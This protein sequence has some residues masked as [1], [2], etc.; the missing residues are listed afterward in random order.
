MKRLF[1][2][3]GD[4]SGD[5][6]AAGVVRHLREKDARIEVAA[7]GGH[8]LERE[9][10]RLLS[11]QSEMGQ[12]GAGAVFGAPYHFFLG[13]KILRFLEEFRPDGVLLIDYGVFNLWMAGRL[14]KRGYRTFYFIPPQV[15]ASR[16][17]RI[18]KI[19]R[20]IDHVFCI[21]P[22]EEPLYREHGVPVTYVGHPLAGALPEPADRQA[23]CTA[24]G[25]D[26][27]RRIIGL[28]PGSRKMEIRYL[29]KPI[30]EAASLISRRLGDHPQF[31]LAQ[32]DA[33]DDGFFNAALSGVLG[34]M[35]GTRPA[36]T[37]VKH[38]NHAVQ[39]V[40]D[41][42]I[43]ASGTAT[44][45]TALYGTPMVLTYRGHWF[46]AMIA[47]RLAYVSCLGLPNILTDMEH[48]IVPEM[49]QEDATPEKISDAL[50]P[51]FDPDSSQYRRAMAGFEQI[52]KTLGSKNATE[53]VASKL[54][55]IL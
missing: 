5:V 22:F 42:A 19:R 31:V 8:A 17:G 40:A 37:V 38:R 36:V 28:L 54:V 53:A 18:K 51:F 2:I 49:L 13:Q 52:R 23:F 30:L 21:F 7:V 10:V 3:T 33:L 55:E 46:V 4:P 32:A 27:S 29:L 39:S 1:I 15:W 41:A 47:R 43:V 44:L 25:L 16:R 6:H 48:P 34:S 35:N 50:M 20:H 24:H 14:K 11:D 45:E 12:V 26:P 9:G